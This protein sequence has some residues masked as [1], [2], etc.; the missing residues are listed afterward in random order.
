MA[1]ASAAV[2]IALN[3]R[4][5]E[6]RDAFSLVG[7][8]IAVELTDG[9]EDVRPLEF[10]LLKNGVWEGVSQAKRDE[11]RRTILLPVREAASVSYLDFTEAGAGRPRDSRR[12][13]G[14]TVARR[15]L[16][17]GWLCAAVVHSFA[18]P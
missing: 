7:G 17:L 15:S 5:R 8:K 3:T 9:A 11:V 1:R 18:V 12:D 10:D 6:V 4:R 14:A 16:Q 2:E 13:A